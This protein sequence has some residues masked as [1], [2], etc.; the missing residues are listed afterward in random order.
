MK[1]LIKDEYF[2]LLHGLEVKFFKSC[3]PPCL[4]MKLK[5]S[6][7]GR[8]SNNLNEA[9][10]EII[11]NDE[12]NVNKDVYAYDMFSLIVDLGSAL[13]LWLGLSA[14]SIFDFLLDFYQDTKGKS[15]FKMK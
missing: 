2:N 5:S 4:T 14:L 15:F 8:F 3:L 7:R 12:I 1:T 10:I 13:G 11:I 6:L 9:F